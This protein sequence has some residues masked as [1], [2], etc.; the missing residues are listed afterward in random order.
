MINKISEN[1]FQLN[2]KIFSSCVYLLKLDD[3]NILIDTGSKDAAVELLE[4]FN[5]INIT[6]EDI[7]SILLTHPH[8][9]HNGN[10]DIFE[11]A[12]IYDFNNIDQL[13]FKDFQVIHVPGHTEDS[14]AFLYDKILFDYRLIS[15]IY[16]P[17]YML[18]MYYKIL[19]I[20]F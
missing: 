6:P 15:N 16:T 13:P 3:N 4:D 19:V 17:H 10:L 20:F 12:K 14:L 11:N 18:R 1:I 8:W 7:N 9:D 2:F 5:E